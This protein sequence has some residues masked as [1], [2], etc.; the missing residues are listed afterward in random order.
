MRGRRNGA[1]HGLALNG[2]FGP[3]S[4]RFGEFELTPQRRRLER[5]GVPVE[6]SSRATDILCVLVERPGQVVT[7]RELLERVWPDVVVD[8]GSIRFHVVALRRALGDGEAGVRVIATVPGRGYCFVGADQPTPADLAQA[9][10]RRA[11]PPR[12]G[13]VVGREGVVEDLAD[14][15]ARRQFVTLVG[16]GGIGKTTIALLA[17]HRWSDLREDPVAFVD[18]GAVT[19][20]SLEAVTDAAAAALGLSVQPGDRVGQVVEQL[21]RRPHLLVLDTCEAAIEGAARFAE[22]V[23]AEAPDVRL[24][25]T[26]REALRVEGEW[27]CRVEPLGRP[28]T[29]AALSAADALRF[30]A[31]QLFVQRAATRQA[32]FELRDEDAPIV[33]AICRDLDGMPLSIELAAGRV[34]AFGVLQVAELL[35]TEFALTWPGRRTA[36]PRLQTLNA[37]LNW[38]HELLSD[39]ERMVF[40]RLAVFAGIFSLEAGVAVAAGEDLEGAV[41]ME[42]LCGLVGKSLLNTVDEGGRSRYR[43]LDTT[44][45][46]ARTRLAASGEEAGAQRR[47]VR[48]YL[49]RLAATADGDVPASEWDELTGNVRAALDWGFSEGGEAEG[50]VQLAA[51][52][53]LLWQQQ[54]LLVDARRWSRLALDQLDRTA[55]NSGADVRLALTGVLINS[56]GLTPEAR[57]RWEADYAAMQSTGD[58]EQQLTG[59]FGLWAHQ[60]RTARYRDA[61]ALIENAD[62]LRTPALHVIYDWLRGVTGYHLGDLDGARIHL[63]RLLGAY[64]EPA[65]RSVMRRFGYD[66]E[67]GALRMTSSLQFLAGRFDEA[68]AFS[69]RAAEKALSLSYAVPSSTVAVWRAFQLYFLDGDEIDSLTRSVIEGGRAEATNSAAGNAMALRGLWLARRGELDRGVELVRRGLAICEGA[70]HAMARAF[71]QAELALQTVRQGGAAAIAV[72]PACEVFAE[73]DPETWCTPEILRIRGELAERQG[74]AIMAEDYY[75]QG[76]EMAR[77]QGAATWALRNAVGLAG[78]WFAQG[79]ANEA[80]EVLTLVLEGFTPEERQPDVRRGRTLLEACQRAGSAGPG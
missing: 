80:A 65:G 48:Y 18:L 28:A 60:I 10:S 78:L 50:A 64:G 54:G 67:S 25:A 22:V 62:V 31:V 74:G 71:I 4:V 70:H 38:S 15:L 45:A 35:S 69:R 58:L 21:R 9:P 79:R 57:R 13:G 6:L 16:P 44:R 40:R 52:A 11:L 61:Q 20:D 1:Y 42:A 17:A 24:L 47:R 27:V 19:P 55:P 2:P 8:E 72:D 36:A 12:P 37:T 30:P 39:V 49:D 3:V 33:G 63:D 43:M 73:P 56:D 23:F 53:A 7:K 5:N 41:A 68:G 26:S 46:Y 66:I 59:L 75:R 34:E 32:G 51:Q 76:F 29:D 77:R 14:R